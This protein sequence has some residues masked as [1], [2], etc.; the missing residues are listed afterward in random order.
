MSPADVRTPWTRPSGG[1]YAGNLHPFLE[2]GAVA[3]GG[4]HVTRGHVGRAR[5]AVA[6]TERA[7]EHVFDV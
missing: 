7:T 6:G 3:A 2:P 5:D 4:R 1:V